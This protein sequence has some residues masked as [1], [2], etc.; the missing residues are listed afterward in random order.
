[1]SV[2]ENHQKGYPIKISFLYLFIGWTLIISG[3]VTWSCYKIKNETM[4]LANKEGYKSYE[5]D[6]MFRIWATA[7]GG[8]YVPVSKLTQ[9]NPYLNVKERDISTPSGKQLT[10]MNP[11]FMTRQVNE[12]SYQR[13]KIISH[14]T[15]LNPIRPMNM[16]DQWETKALNEFERGAKSYSGLDTIQSQVYYRYMAPLFVEKGCLKCHADQ[17]YKLGDIRGGLST[18][19]L[20]TKYQATYDVQLLNIFLGYGLLWLVGMIGLNLVRSKFVVY[21]AERKRADELKN[22]LFEEIQESNNLLET[23]LYEKNALI[24]E[25][26]QTKNSLEKSNSEKDKFFS[27]L[28]HDLKS[29]FAG[30]LGLTEMFAEDI[31]R[32]SEADM[33]N[34]AINMQSS[35]GNLYKLL[36]N[37][38]EWSRIQRGKIEFN[39]EKC[40]ISYIVRQNIEIQSEVSR[41]KE[42]TIVNTIEEDVFA[43]ADVQMVNTVIRNL[44]SNSI[45]FTPRGGRIEI[46]IDDSLIESI[47]PKNYICIYVKDSGVGMN[48]STIAKLFKIDEKV[49][50]PGTEGEPSTGLGLLL[51][52]EFIEMNSGKIW[53]ESQVGIGTAF[54]FILPISE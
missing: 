26:S 9:P 46:G 21:V 24:E 19:V 7:H 49:S 27:I 1:M 11:A 33:K 12:L 32:F 34:L 47:V 31:S 23:A 37:L 17:G 22:K 51:C 13:Y 18:A 41:L 25:L 48:E 20:W 43:H 5:K 38:L 14:I 54:K 28:A 36:E 29:P 8:V 42:I 15:S 35:A 40:I 50:R 45:K 3:I 53:V 2:I 44:L 6:L 30:F 4:Q 39:P 52:K 10:L 16:P